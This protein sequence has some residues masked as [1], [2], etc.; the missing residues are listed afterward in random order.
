MKTIIQTACILILMLSLNIDSS[1]QTKTFEVLNPKVQQGDV[2]IVNIVPI[3]GLGVFPQPTILFLNKQYYP[4]RYGDVFIGIDLNT[5]PGRYPVTL[6]DHGTGRELSPDYF[7]EVDITDREFTSRTRGMFIPTLRRKRERDV[8]NKAFGDGDYSDRYFKDEFVKPL[9]KIILDTD[10]KVG[11]I[12]SPF[13]DGHAGVDLVTLDRKSGQN[14]RPVKAINSGKVAL[15]A[16]N[17]STDGNMV[18][19]DH[20]SGIF[21]VYMHLSSFKV[22]K[23]GDMVN[24]DDIIAISGNTGSAKRG[25][26]HLHFA[27]KIRDKNKV[28]DVYVDPLAFI[29]TMNQYV[30]QTP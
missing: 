17:F 26:P 21:S 12:S 23:V 27:V 1:A 22:K 25:G 9:D 5:K 19:L 3:F 8:I 30:K 13:G 16:K 2:L 15:I 20:G 18:I 24:K 6:V 11:D 4:N 29:D 10:R 14:K 7:V 28:S